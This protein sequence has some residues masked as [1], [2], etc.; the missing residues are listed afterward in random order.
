[1]TF[2]VTSKLCVIGVNLQIELTKLDFRDK[3][4]RRDGTVSLTKLANEFAT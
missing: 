4:A 1:M 3:I 2:V